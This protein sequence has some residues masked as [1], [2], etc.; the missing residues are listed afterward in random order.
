L[1]KWIVDWGPL[2]C[3]LVT[4]KE[5]KNEIEYKKMDG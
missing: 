2:Q 4:R 5:R 1:A 3:E